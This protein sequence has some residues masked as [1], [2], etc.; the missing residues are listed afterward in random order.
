VS[1]RT[2]ADGS[3]ALGA[4]VVAGAAEAGRA[5]GLLGPSSSSVEASLEALTGTRYA[6]VARTTVSPP[7]LAI[8]EGT[9]L[10]IAVR[11]L[12]P[13]EL[14]ARA[15]GTAGS[16]A[17]ELGAEGR[18]TSAP[19]LEIR[20]AGRTTRFTGADLFTGGSRTVELAGATLTLGGAPHDVV[21]GADGTRAAG[22]ADAL[23]ATLPGGGQ[24]RMG[25]VEASVTVPPGGVACTS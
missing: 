16:A 2:T 20:A 14:T 15:G 22:A 21:V 13:L 9:P 1:A 6:L 3:C 5:S 24:V 25:H 19:M 12:G 17:V 23:I 10:E 7:A 18:D 8:A 11:F 4:P